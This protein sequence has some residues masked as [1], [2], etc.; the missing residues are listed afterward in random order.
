ME[1]ESSL[2]DSD[3][4]FLPDALLIFPP[5]ICDVKRKINLQTPGSKIKNFK[6]TT[7]GH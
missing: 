4:V 1:A 5:I 7:A 2:P 6:M 3:G